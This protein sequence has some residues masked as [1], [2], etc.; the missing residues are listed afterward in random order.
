MEFSSL[1]NFYTR[2]Y[3]ARK[4][5]D[6]I[7]SHGRCWKKPKAQVKYDEFK[8]CKWFAGPRHLFEHC[9]LVIVL[10]RRNG[11]PIYKLKDSQPCSKS[12]G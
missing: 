12:H 10:P 6:Q 11:L 9:P 8:S 4:E 1:F 3:S 2:R 7:L 5:K